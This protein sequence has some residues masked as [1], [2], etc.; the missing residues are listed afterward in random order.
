MG[1]SIL[2]IDTAG[3]VVGVCMWSDE[4]SHV[5]TARVGRDADS[6]I[7]PVLA[8]MLS[9]SSP[10]AVAVTIGPGAFTGL[11]VGVS[12]ALG[13]A[14]ALGIPVV[15]ISSLVARAHLVETDDRV[16]ALLDA[17]KSRF[18]GQWFHGQ[19]GTLSPSGEAQDLPLGELLHGGRFVAVGEGALVAAD[20]IRAAGGVVSQRA[21]ECPVS[22]VGKLAWSARD[23]AVDPGQVALAYLREP[24]ARPGI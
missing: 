15:P 3:P 14:T 21:G 13:V 19:S 22:M 7:G 18:Y 4:D 1:Q 16:L 17:R 9:L 24:D 2:A 5:W 12:A 6:A 11:R 20:A 10:V 8:E 23:R